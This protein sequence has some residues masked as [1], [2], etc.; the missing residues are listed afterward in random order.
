MQQEFLEA[1]VGGSLSALMESISSNEHGPHPAPSTLASFIGMAAA[2]FLW[3]SV[4]DDY[5]D[6]TAAYEIVREAR[7]GWPAFRSLAREVFS[8]GSLDVLMYTGMVFFWRTG[9]QA[10]T[11]EVGWAFSFLWFLRNAAHR[12]AAFSIGQI[13]ERRGVSEFLSFAY[14]QRPL[15]DFQDEDYRSIY[16]AYGRP[17]ANTNTAFVWNWRNGARRIGL[18]RL[19][20]VRDNP[21]F[22][23]DLEDA[24][25]DRHM[26]VS[27]G[28]IRVGDPVARGIAQSLRQRVEWD[29]HSNDED[30]EKNNE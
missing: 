21:D 17:L 15:V 18:D 27:D 16:V 19:L 30:D 25:V 23:H 4:R 24:G 3:A 8:S 14:E 10:G 20:H 22:V 5:A 12:V 7:S 13:A 2:D 9:A 28:L 6:G 1:V 29:R 11:T 26:S